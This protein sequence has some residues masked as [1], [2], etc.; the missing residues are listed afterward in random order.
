MI[1]SKSRIEKIRKKFS[2]LR[3]K[4]SES[5][6]NEIR[7]SLQEKQNEKK[8]FPPKIEEIRKNLLELEENFFNP[9]KY[10]DYDDIEYKGIRDVKDLF[11]FSIDEDYYKPRI[12]N[13]AFNNQYIQYESK[14]NKDKILTTSE[15]LNMI[16]L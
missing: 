15:Y 9:K 11:D 5:K 13:S 16:R 6:I 4:F 2:E 3:Y 12:T 10:Y 1:F 14:G 7:K 8:L